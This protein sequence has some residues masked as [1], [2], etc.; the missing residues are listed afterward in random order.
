MTALIRTYHNTSHRTVHIGS[1]S[2]RGLLI[3]VIPGDSPL[4]RPQQ[5][6]AHWWSMRVVHAHCSHTSDQGRV[7]LHSFQCEY[8][9]TTMEGSDGK[10]TD[11]SLIH[12]LYVLISVYCHHL[13]YRRGHIYKGCWLLHPIRICDSSNPIGGI[14]RIPIFNW[15]ILLFKVLTKH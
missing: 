11:P 1:V 14:P 2:T 4:L 5:N 9:T 15:L 13:V 12:I 3:S 6:I 8:N 10:S 7:K